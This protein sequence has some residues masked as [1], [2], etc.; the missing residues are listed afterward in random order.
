MSE[1]EDPEHEAEEMLVW[2]EERAGGRLHIQLGVNCADGK[3]VPVRGEKYNEYRF[4]TDADCA[5]ETT[6]KGDPCIGITDHP[7]DWRGLPKSQKFYAV[8]PRQHPDKNLL[9]LD[10]DFGPGKQFETR[11][12]LKAGLPPQWFSELPHT[13]T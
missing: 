4:G 9:V 5:G 6:S 11:E 12:A 7:G 3:K 10:G 1:D 8:F 2:L 13:K